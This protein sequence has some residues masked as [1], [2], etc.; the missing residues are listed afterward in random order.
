MVRNILAVL[1]GLAVGVI[2]MTGMEG[3]VA[4]LHP[5]PASLNMQDKEGMAAYIASMPASAVIMMAVTYML[6]SFVAGYTASRISKK[7]R[8][9]IVVG[10]ILLIAGIANVVT[11]H[12]PL[13]MAILFLALYVPFAWLGGKL[14]TAGT[15]D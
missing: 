1:A 6:S 10:C 13:W 14:A 7:I 2:V 5:M 12:H 15:K 11:Y 9:S 4:K 8:Q 3:Y